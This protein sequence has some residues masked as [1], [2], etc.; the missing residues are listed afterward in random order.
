VLLR[1]ATPGADSFGNVWA[2]A[3]DV[4]EVSDEQGRTLLRI[5]DAGFS[6]V[7]P[8]SVPATFSEVVN[9]TPAVNRPVQRPRTIS[10]R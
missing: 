8:F 9:D 4:V 3:D 2:K 1:K 6:E 10:R 5:Q 7:A